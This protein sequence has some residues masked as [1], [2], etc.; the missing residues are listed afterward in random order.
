MLIGWAKKYIRVD[1]YYFM[2]GS[3]FWF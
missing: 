3:L 2:V 1:R